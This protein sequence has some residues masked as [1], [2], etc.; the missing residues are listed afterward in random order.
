[1]SLE[2]SKYTKKVYHYNIYK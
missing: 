2:L 1:M